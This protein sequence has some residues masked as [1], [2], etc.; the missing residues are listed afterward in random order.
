[1]LSITGGG[2]GGGCMT[3]QLHMQPPDNKFM[4]T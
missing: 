3:M 2:G 1:M 4:L